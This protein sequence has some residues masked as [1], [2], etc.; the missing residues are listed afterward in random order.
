MSDTHNKSDKS[1]DFRLPGHSSHPHTL[2]KASLA[3]TAAYSATINPRNLEYFWYIAWDGIC[4][5]LVADL[6]NAVVA[7]QFP[8]WFLPQTDDAEDE[9]KEDQDDGQ[10][11]A[12]EDGENAGEGNTDGEDS[13]SPDSLPDV[14][15][16][17]LSEL[18]DPNA[19]GTPDYPTTTLDVDDILFA[20]SPSARSISAPN[21]AT[22]LP[23]FVIAILEVEKRLVARRFAYGGEFKALLIKI[24][25]LVEIK[26]CVARSLYKSLRQREKLLL[27]VLKDGQQGVLEQAAH[28]FMNHPDHN[29]VI[30]IAASGPDWT[31]AVIRR[32]HVL[33]IMDSI[34]HT[35]PNYVPQSEDTEDEDPAPIPEPKWRKP[36]QIGGARSHRAFGAIHKILKTLADKYLGC[37]PEDEE[38]STP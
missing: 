12:E 10:D 23:D 31:W 30:G 15:S 18:E 22:R 33:H 26:A 24:G 19:E 38:A 37:L 32:C 3:T 2:L 20:E 7:P 34:R 4:H 28:L 27:T 16:E 6:Q 5:D 11:D 21:A 14:A 13:C 35:D 8:L 25:A 17:E 9:N 1:W 36:M 29:S